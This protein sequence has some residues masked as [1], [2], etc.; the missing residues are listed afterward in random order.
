MDSENKLRAWGATIIAWIFPGM[1]HV[2]QGRFLQGIL[3]GAVAATLFVLGV[4]LGGYLQTLSNSETGILARVFWFC[5]LGNG[6]LYVVPVY[7]GV[8][9]QERPMLQ[10]A[11]YGNIFL[12]ASG[13]LN[14]F[15][16]LDAYDTA[17]GRKS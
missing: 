4:S 6:L 13:L 16:M 8:A 10:Y 12:V 1:G 17:V 11:E 9:V 3:L 7:L 15:I 14:Y 5:N 2:V